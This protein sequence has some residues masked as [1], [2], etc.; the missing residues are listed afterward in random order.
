MMIKNT[1]A[2]ENAHNINQ[3]IR[4]SRN[5]GTNGF[6]NPSSGRSRLTPAPAGGMVVNFNAPIDSVSAGREISRV[7]SDFNRASGRR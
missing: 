7:L 6:V 3:N 1:A 4:E 2:V 5:P